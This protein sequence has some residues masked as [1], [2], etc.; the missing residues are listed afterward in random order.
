MLAR[1][2]NANDEDDYKNKDVNDK[3]EDAC[4]YQQYLLAILARLTGWRAISGTVT[5]RAMVEVYKLA[6]SLVKA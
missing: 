2:K 6:S 4:V 3:D 1:T 5:G